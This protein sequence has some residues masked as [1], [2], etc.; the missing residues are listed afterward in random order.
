MQSV[1]IIR[2]D[3]YAK[4]PYCVVLCNIMQ[5]RGRGFDG[6]LVV[7]PEPVYLDV[8]RVLGAAQPFELVLEQVEA[9]ET[10]MIVDLAGGSP[11]QPDRHDLGVASLGLFHEPELVAPRAVMHIT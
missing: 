9:V 2:S 3:L 6:P 11:D 4:C 7:Q 1:L 10:A 5:S 8:V